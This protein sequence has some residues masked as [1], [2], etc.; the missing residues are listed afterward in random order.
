MQYGP[1]P[2]A[3]YPNEAIKSMCYIKNVVTR[4]TI[5][6]GDYT[7]YDDI[8]GAEKFEDHVTQH[9]EFIGDK[10]IIGRF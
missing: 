7:Y 1:D 10:L 3:I 2:N 6:V 5:I 4:P 9:Y 8:T